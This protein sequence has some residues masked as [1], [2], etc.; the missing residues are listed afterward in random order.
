VSHDPGPSYQWSSGSGGR[1]W[2]RV[3]TYWRSGLHIYAGKR[4]KFRYEPKY[5]ENMTWK[6]FTQAR[7]QTN[8]KKVLHLE[9]SDPGQ[10]RVYWSAY[11]SKLN[12]GSIAGHGFYMPADTCQDILGRCLELVRQGFHQSHECDWNVVVL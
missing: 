7:V 10:P 4:T 3:P 6:A 9:S 11:T 12:R 8:K 1:L 2:T 5:R